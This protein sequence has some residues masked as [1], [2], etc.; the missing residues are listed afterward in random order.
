MSYF[1]KKVIIPINH[2]DKR[3]KIVYSKYNVKLQLKFIERGL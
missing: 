2:L 3:F 1:L